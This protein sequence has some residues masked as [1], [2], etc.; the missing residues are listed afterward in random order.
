MKKQVLTR[1]GGFTL[2]E[3]MI[4]VAIVAILAAIAYPSYQ[5][6]VQRSWRANAAACLTELAQRMERRYTTSSSYVGTTP[7]VSGCTNEGNMGNRYAFSFAAD[8]TAGAFTLRAVPTDP[9]PQADD[10]CGTLT[11]NALGQKGAAGSVNECWRR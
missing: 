10:S 9:G 3:L 1:S 2:I 4:T 8:P 11:I 6:S 7:P 5:R